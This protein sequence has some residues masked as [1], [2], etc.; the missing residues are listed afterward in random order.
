MLQEE[1]EE[2]AVNKNIWETLNTF[3]INKATFEQSKDI[4]SLFSNKK[5]TLN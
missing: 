1:E 4:D 3:T 2:M 5:L